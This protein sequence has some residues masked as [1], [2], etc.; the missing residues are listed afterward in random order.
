MIILDRAQSLS[1]RRAATGRVFVRGAEGTGKSSLANA[2]AVQTAEAG[3]ACLLVGASPELDRPLDYRLARP[4]HSILARRAL[5]NGR[6]II[7]QKQIDPI[8]ARGRLDPAA[9]RLASRAFSCARELIQ[10]YGLNE[11]EVAHSL[12]V[13]PIPPH[14][15]DLLAVV[16]QDANRIAQI[17]WSGNRRS[18]RSL[19]D[20]ERVIAG[21]TTNAPP[22]EGSLALI[23]ADDANFER[24]LSSI[25]GATPHA[26]E[27]DLGML[28]DSLRNPAPPD[29][30][31]RQVHE[32]IVQTTQLL[33][34]A[35][36]LVRT[37]GS[38]EAAMD[39]ESSSQASKIVELFLQKRPGDGTDAAV[40]FFANVVRQFE[41]DENALAPYLERYGARSIGSIAQTELDKPIPFS[42][43]FPRA[44]SYVQNLREARYAANQFPGRMAQLRAILSAP[45]VREIADM[46]IEKTVKSVD[47]S[48]MP[49][50]RAKAAQEVRQLRDLFASTGFGDLFSAPADFVR[51]ADE[52]L[53]AQQTA[54]VTN[55]SSGV[56]DLLLEATTP[57][58]SA[59]SST[60]KEWPPS[61][62]R[63]RTRSELTDIASR[64]DRF[65]VLVAD[66]A[67]ACEDSALEKFAAAGT[68]VHLI[69]TDKDGDVVVLDI[70]HR[71]INFELADLASRRQGYWLAG[72]TGSGLVVHETVGAKLE[73]L[74]SEATRLTNSLRDLG[75]EAVLSDGGECAVADF[76][77]AA[78]D[79]L[80]D[81]GVLNLAKRA[82][83]GIFILC[84][85]DLRRLV[86]PPER[87][88]TEDAI[89]ARS[90]GWKIKRA[91]SEGVVLEKDDR[92][93][94]LVDEPVA[95]TGS[96]DLVMDVVDRLSAL[97]WRP[98]VAWR[99]APRD[100]DDLE[101]LLD[102]HSSSLPGETLR[103]I[104][105]P[106]GLSQS[107]P[108]LGEDFHHI[109]LRPEEVAGESSGVLKSSSGGG[110]HPSWQD[111]DVIRS[112][113][114]ESLA[115]SGAREATS[116]VR[117]VSVVISPAAK[118][119]AKAPDTDPDNRAG[120]V[121]PREQV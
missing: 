106:F 18:G 119:E 65:D 69:G 20:V 52:S 3:L 92:A 55:H 23:L 96:E 11:E 94:A 82:R 104:A 80:T 51:R 75:R 39:A 59:K 95:L 90:L 115:G 17:L 53:I 102:R 37:G 31:L 67:D 113:D 57:S 54:T 93:V 13:G 77:V 40:K 21:R 46:P 34:D 30:T 48:T 74:K 27:R 14:A 7:R 8:E 41:K 78:I 66:D 64:D 105:E 25:L 98:L 79:E 117:V 81:A 58:A 10:R 87:S 91:C 1:L 22:D 62:V 42:S 49:D 85:R 116:L 99:D 103:A 33:R 70:P 71:Q 73:Y 111:A 60:K 100:P 88:L 120:P 15:L 35:I 36:D 107:V 5:V 43:E 44:G 112:A 118:E 50:K 56:L 28:I 89:T 72:P 16:A 86:S 61:V 2:I 6:P 83:E 38:L 68:R 97:G 29:K 108:R 9:M 26:D 19:D 12:A 114:Q 32:H 109:K 121:A 4:C 76:V 110:G 47:R 84:R 101:R 45:L 63:A 24:K